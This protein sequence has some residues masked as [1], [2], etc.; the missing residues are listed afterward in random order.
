[1]YNLYVYICESMKQYTILKR[2][3]L[4]YDDR[5]NTKIFENIFSTSPLTHSQ[6]IKYQSHSQ[7]S[8][9]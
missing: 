3:S 9:E 6:T 4:A 5:T 2:V 8:I 7:L 1:M